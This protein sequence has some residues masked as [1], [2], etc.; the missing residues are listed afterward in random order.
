MEC[1]EAVRR[2][3]WKESSPVEQEV[4]GGREENSRSVSFK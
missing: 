3:F 4:G 1:L 2:I